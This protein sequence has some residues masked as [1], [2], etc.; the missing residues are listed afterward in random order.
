LAGVPAVRYE[1]I[2][3]TVCGL[4]A[5]VAGV[6]LASRLS[7]GQTEAGAGYE[8]LSIATA[9]IGGVAIGGGIGTIS[10]V[11]LGTVFI[12]VLATGLDIAGVGAYQQAMITGVVIV[13]AGLIALMRARDVRQ[14]LRRAAENISRARPAGRRSVRVRS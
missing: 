12:Q 5:G 2:A 1:I 9:V 13:A 8:L 11:V 14:I 7:V 3:Y 6:I 4:L 10:G